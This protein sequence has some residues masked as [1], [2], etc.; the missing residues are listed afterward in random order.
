MFLVV[1][2]PDVVAEFTRRFYIHT[3]IS[4]DPSIVTLALDS[5]LRNSGM[6]MSPSKTPPLLSRHRTTALSH[7]PPPLNLRRASTTALSY[8]CQ[9]AFLCLSR[10]VRY[11][12]HIHSTGYVLCLVVLYIPAHLASRR[13][14]LVF[15][16]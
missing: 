6:T 11:H 1:A 10:I 12:I 13:V 3:S 15:I 4:P 8:D 16:H 9:F 14:F 2:H 7:Y 5:R